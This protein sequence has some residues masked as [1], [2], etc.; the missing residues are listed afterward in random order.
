MADQHEAGVGGA[1]GRRRDARGNR[2]RDGE[3]PHGGL[4]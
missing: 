4:A 1:R 3:C 2:E